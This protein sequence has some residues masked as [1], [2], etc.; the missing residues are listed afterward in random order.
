LLIYFSELTL[1]ESLENILKDFKM[2]DDS[3]F[4]FLSWF[5][6]KKYNFYIKLKKKYSKGEKKD[7]LRHNVTNFSKNILK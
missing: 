7:Y 3:E 5:L 6:L 4:Q 1:A 2:P